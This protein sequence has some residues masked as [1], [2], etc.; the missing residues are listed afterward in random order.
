MKISSKR[1]LG[2]KTH[3]ENPDESFL[4][5]VMKKISV[6]KS[7]AKV[8][9]ALVECSFD[10]PVETFFEKNQKFF[11]SKSK[12]PFL[13]KTMFLEMTLGTPKRQFQRFYRNFFAK[14]PN[15]FTQIAKTSIDFYVF[16]M[17]IIFS[18]CSCGHRD[19]RD[20]NAAKKTSE[21]YPRNSTGN[22]F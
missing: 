15:F 20:D 1:T 8:T 6:K 14:I 19:D 17:S 18:Q 2:L 13:M 4:R 16:P 9:S 21:R 12:N 3:F 7:S 5:D 10:N 11:R 22:I